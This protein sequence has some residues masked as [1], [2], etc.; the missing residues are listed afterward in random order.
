[1][2]ANLRGGAVMLLII[3][4]AG[5]I[6]AQVKSRTQVL[7]VNGH[8][9]EASVVELN[10]REYVDLQALVRLGAGSLGFE[11]DRLVV[12]FPSPVSAPVNAPASDKPS[13]SGFSRDFMKAGI[14]Q[15][16]LMREWASPLASA[17]QN[18]YPITEEWVAQYREQAQNGLRLASVAASTEDDHKGLQLLQNEFDAVRE[19][20]VRLMN[21]RKSMDTAKYAMS[22]G[23]L[24]NDA[25]SQKIIGCAHFL[26]PML[27]SGSFQD[28]PACH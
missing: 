11:Q 19:W 16:A 17:I 2:Q 22:E 12:T 21:A 24:R 14:E 25:L 8:L 3:V 26:A 23:A 28:D 4:S 9:G 1:M 13:N 5:I 27:G 7:Q 20:S 10:G 18:G 15:M 6:V